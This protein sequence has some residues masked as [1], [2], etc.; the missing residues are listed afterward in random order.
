[1]YLN[2]TPLRRNYLLILFF[3][4]LSFSMVG[5]I[6]SPPGSTVPFG[7]NSSYPGSGITPT[8]LPTG[9]AYGASQDA[10]DAYLDWKSSYVESCG[11]SNPE[12]FRVKFDNTSE[13]V[14]EGIAYGMLLAAYAADQEL[15]DG[16]WDYYKHFSNNNG[17]MNWK[18]NGCNNAIGTGGATDAELD[19]AMA[20]LVADHQWPNTTSPHDYQADVTALIDAIKTFEIQPVN[21]NGPYQTNNG[22]GWGFGNNCRNPSY[23]SPAYYKAFGAFNS[24]QSTFWNQCINA[25]YALLNTNAHVTTGLVSNWCDHTGIPNSCNGANDYG[26]DACRNP[27]RMGTDVLWYSDANAAALCD[28]MANWMSGVGVNNLRAPLPQNGS[29]GAYVNPAFISTWAVG[30]MGA[31][32]SYQSL[33]NEM[34]DKTVDT[35]IQPP[36]GYFGNTLRVIG[37]FT[38][39]G[40]FWNPFN[41]GGSN[42][43]APTASFTLSPSSGQAPLAVS[44]DASASSDPDG[45]PLSYFWNFGDGNSATG[46]VVNHTYTTAGTFTAIL[47]VN[48]GNGGTGSDSEVVTVSG[49]NGGGGNGP[50]DLVLQ[51][52]TFDNTPSSTTD[53]HIRPHFKINNEGNTSISLS[54]LTIRYWYTKEGTSG[55]SIHVDWAQ[56]G[57]QNVITNIVQMAAPTTGADHYL[58][59]GFTSGA[60]SIPANG[61]SGQ[62]QTRFH[63]NNWSNYSELD[64]YSF[65]MSFNTFQ[66]WDKVTLYC[67]GQL[68]WGTEPGGNPPSNNPPNADFSLT[69]SSG[70]APL[71]VSFDASASS[72]PDG[73]PLTYAWDFGDGNTGNGLA[74]SHTYTSTGTFT[75]TLT[76]DDGNGGTDTHTASITVNGSPPANNPPTADFSLTPTSG[77]APLVVSFDASASFDP[78]GD[79][80]TYAWDF[81]DGNSGNGLMVNHTYTT[82]GTFTATLT[83]D[84]GNG[85]TDTHTASITVSS[86]PS[87]NP[88]NADFSLTP[89]SGQAPLAVSF[90]ASASSD[91]DGDPLTYAWDFGDGSTGSGIS[92]DHTYTTVGTFTITLTVDDGNGGTDTHNGSVTVNSSGGGGSCDLVVQYRT[93]DNNQSSATDNHV[94][95][96]FRINNNGNTAID[97]SDVTLRYW[98][99]KEGSGVE[100]IHVDWAQVGRQNILTSTVQLGTPGTGADH[101]MEVGFKAAAGSIAANGTSGPIQ[102]RFHKNNWSNYNETDDHSFNMN[103][104]SFQDWSN[105]TLYCNGQLAWGTEPAGA[106]QIIV[107]PGGHTSASADV[108]TLDPTTLKGY[109]NP[110]ASQLFV[111]TGASQIFI[112]DSLGKLVK[113]VVV[114]H[115]HRQMEIDL[116]D[117]PEGLYFLKAGEQSIRVVKKY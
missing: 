113:K 73:D 46:E 20:L 74:V 91:P 50:C 112:F 63:K 58:E 89:S 106:Q 17:V 29:G 94:R 54:D 36:G 82:T 44:F 101:Y 34:Y 60:G 26:W 25:S 78:D 15:F 3:I 65:D 69:P 85:E 103:F 21:Q 86:P 37:L 61:S 27:W 56:V 99:T 7:S 110:F 87:N 40:N 66:D 97:L 5:Q 90:D 83:V 48:D 79:P 57:S 107:P 114:N 84:D 108:I 22:D 96:H 6:N 42:N 72:D 80:L 35:Y 105:V 4:G 32:S 116:S 117:I 24:S 9:G 30:V 68:T 12:R 10:A 100:S 31:N 52:R 8:N 62:V 76:V 75:A 92:P 1:M 59:V 81:G 41:T 14:S 45:D 109:P 16:L 55:E 47:T 95:P 115:L 38:L 77:Q 64:D 43:N 33:L 104:S 19:A 53:N 67:N 70:Q 13:T 2:A 102:T 93:N 39:T 18:I 111:E 88:P 71:A 23:Q 11:G 98:Y 51:Y 49:N 28:K